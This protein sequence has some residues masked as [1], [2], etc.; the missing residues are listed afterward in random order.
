VAFKMAKEEEDDERALRRFHARAQQY[1]EYLQRRSARGWLRWRPQ[2]RGDQLDRE[3]RSLS[4][5]RT[6]QR[7]RNLRR[8]GK[9]VDREMRKQTAGSHRRRRL[10]LIGLVVLGALLLGLALAV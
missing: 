8:V 9:E 1:D 10:V 6:R 2:R 7:N 4:N 5:R 3:I